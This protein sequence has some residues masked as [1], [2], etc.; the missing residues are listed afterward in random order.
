MSESSASESVPKSRENGT[1]VAG[2]P[3]S[4]NQA[5]PFLLPLSIFNNDSLSALEAITKYLKEDCSL[6]YCEIAAALNRDDR[7]IWGAYDSA[8]KKSALP[9]AG[10]GS[11]LAIPASV[12]C[13]RTL[14]TLEALVR[15]ARE[16]LNL[17]YRQIAT[18]LNRDYRT[19]WTVYSR[20]RKK[21]GHMR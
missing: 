14:S 3:E 7:T 10:G 8:R 19:I 11:S 12:F 13:D 21:R 20:A 4:G 9:L 15:H 5:E 6:R 2:F 1:E 17:G 18:L 16:E